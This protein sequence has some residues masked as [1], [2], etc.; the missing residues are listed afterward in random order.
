MQDIGTGV[1]D[2][3]EMTVV[4]YL[5]TKVV[6]WLGIGVGTCPV[7]R[8]GQGLRVVNGL[9]MRVVRDLEVHIQRNLS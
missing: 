1:V 5:R 4:N 8:F 6:G 2:G 3:L 9:G 7:T